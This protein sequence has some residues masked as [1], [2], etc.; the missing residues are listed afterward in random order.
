MK[1][2]VVFRPEAEEDLRRAY[3]W[4][5]EQRA[6]LGQ[7]FLLCIEAVVAAINENPSRFPAVHKEVRRALL[8][9]FPYAVFYLLQDD[10]ISVLAV[11][12]CSRDPQYWQSRAA[13]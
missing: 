8:R 11:F 5:E 7:D 1:Y 9:R 4:Y 12:H 6:G 2:T 10:S 13:E 3:R